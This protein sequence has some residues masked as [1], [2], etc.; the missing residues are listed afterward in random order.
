MRLKVKWIALLEF[1][2][3]VI[4]I[5]ALIKGSYVNTVKDTKANTIE[6]NTLQQKKSSYKLLSPRIAAGILE[7]KNFMIAHFNDLEDAMRRYIKDNNI[8]ASVFVENLRN[9]ATLSINT[10]EGDFPASINKLPVAI[11]IMQNI[12]R[13]IIGFD[14]SLMIDDE[15]IEDKE[16]KL[17]KDNKIVKVRV[18]LEKMLVESDNTAYQVLLKQVDEKDLRLLAAYYGLDAEG[19]YTWNTTRW[20]KNSHLSPRILANIFSSLYFST[21]LEPEHSEYLLYLLTNTTFDIHEIAHLPKDV[22]IAQKYGY[23]DLNN[24]NLLSDCGIMYIGQSRVLYCITIRNT[25]KQTALNAL[26]AFVNVIHTYVTDTRNALD[27]FKKQ[28][29]ISPPAAT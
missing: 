7:P 13:G 25:D 17:Y 4:L 6:D 23:Y 9:G 2:V 27:I 20:S 24:F 10:R 11:L 26:G 1:I 29:Y 12:E 3:I 28:G 8:N 5:L 19:A 18:L 16:D 14:S 22:I 15:Q 21:V